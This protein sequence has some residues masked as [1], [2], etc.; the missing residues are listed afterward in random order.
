M[1]NGIAEEISKF[2]SSIEAGFWLG[3]L[4]CLILFT[5]LS[6]G[7]NSDKHK[8]DV[9]R[10]VIAMVVL[11]AGST[12]FYITLLCS[13]EYKEAYTNIDNIEWRLHNVYKVDVDHKVYSNVRKMIKDSLDDNIISVVENNKIVKEYSKVHQELIKMKNGTDDASLEKI[14][15]RLR[16]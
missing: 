16:Q 4:I 7:F 13:K 11:I 14:K 3:V 2:N 9:L 12:Y 5:M 6:Y 10:F 15:E 1:D 8:K